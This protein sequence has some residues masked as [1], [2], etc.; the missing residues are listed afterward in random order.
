MIEVGSLLSA[1]LVMRGKVIGW[2]LGL[3]F[4]IGPFIGYILSGSVGVP[5]DPGDVGNWGHLLGT[6]SLVVEGSFVIL[7]AA[8]LTRL[9]RAKP[10]GVVEASQRVITYRERERQNA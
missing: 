6:V 2:I 7:A 9:S 3:A 5:G 4:T 1:L 10:D 8:C